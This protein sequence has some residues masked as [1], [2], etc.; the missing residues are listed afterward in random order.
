MGRYDLHQGGPLRYS[1]QN[2]KTFWKPSGKSVSKSEISR[3]QK[4]QRREVSALTDIDAPLQRCNCFNQVTLHQLAL[5]GSG[6]RHGE[7]VWVVGR[8]GNPDP[9]FGN[10][11]PGDEFSEVGEAPGHPRARRD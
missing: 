9:L 4:V 3:S 1:L 2:R 11:Y 10:C 8:L 6:M 5:T 7:A